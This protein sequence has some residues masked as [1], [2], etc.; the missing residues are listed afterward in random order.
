MTTVCI[1]TMTP[2]DL[3]FAA[4]C[5]AAVGWG[6]QRGEFELFYAH[7]AEGCLVAEAGDAPGTPNA[8]GASPMAY[9]VGSP[10]KG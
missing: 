7:D 10:A 3:D 6:A 5:T 4:S 9:A 1:R 8:L 2:A